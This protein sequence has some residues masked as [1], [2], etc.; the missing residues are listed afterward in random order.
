MDGFFG[1]Q[2]N[3]VANWA[4]NNGNGTLGRK[5]QYKNMGKWDGNGG[6]VCGME[7]GDGSILLFRLGEEAP[8]SILP[9]LFS[10]FIAQLDE[11]EVAIRLPPLP[12]TAPRW[13]G[14][15][16]CGFSGNWEKLFT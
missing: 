4:A 8:C 16:E 1:G 10:N 11:S 12:A 3:L 6:N 7:D 15:V 5:R 14:T 13:I 9:L 2:G